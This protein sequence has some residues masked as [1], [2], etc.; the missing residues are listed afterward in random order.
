MQIISGAV[1][2]QEALLLETSL[3]KQADAEGRF[4]YNVVRNT[5]T[6]PVS[7]MS[8]PATITPNTSW[9]NPALYS[10]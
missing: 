8:I 3:I 10:R 1:P 4:L 5:I 6:P 7:P 2:R 9:L